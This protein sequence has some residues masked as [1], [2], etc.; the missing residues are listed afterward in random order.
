MTAVRSRYT[1][2]LVNQFDFSGISNALEVAYE[3]ER[4]DA[5][6]FQDTGSTSLALSTAAT[7]TQNGYF[8]NAAAGE[9]EQEVWESMANS[10]TLYV[11]A[12]F[13]TDTP[14]CAAHV[15]RATN[16]GKLN[17]K[18]EIAGLITVGGEWFQGV[19]ALY[20]RRVWSGTF[21][22]TGAQTTPGY[23]DLGAAGAAGGYVW[24]FVQSITG[25]ATNATINVQSDDN[26]GFSSPATEATFTFGAVG[27]YEQAMS[28]AVDR[29]LRLNVTSMGG[30]TNFTVVAIAAV[31][32]VTY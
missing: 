29:Y 20:G 18:A 21:S 23:I 28:G 4:I 13:G 8:Q 30:A 9:F 5:T 27:G 3:V 1:R 32:G 19:G 17:I 11:A 15:A 7:I 26:T 22:A 6:A 25:T 12:L 24:L 14:A 16:T 2:L 10:E 31:S